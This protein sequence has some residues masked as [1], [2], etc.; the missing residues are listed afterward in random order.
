M[1]GNKQTE[2]NEEDIAKTNQIFNIAERPVM[3]FISKFLDEPLNV[4][5]NDNL[6]TYTQNLT[7]LPIKEY[8]EGVCVKFILKPIMSDS[9]NDDKN[10]SNNIINE[11]IKLEKVKEGIGY[12]WYC[13]KEVFKSL[14][15][16]SMINKAPM[17]NITIE[18]NENTWEFYPKYSHEITQKKNYYENILGELMHY[19]KNI[20]KFP[21][22]LLTD[23]NEEYI[24]TINELSIINTEIDSMP[25]LIADEKKINESYRKNFVLGIFAEECLESDLPKVK[26]ISTKN[27]NE[28]NINENVK[29]NI[30][31]EL[32]ELFT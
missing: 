24:K 20:N 7:L 25:T 2:K 28:N 14:V 17:E 32:T 21:E 4:I 10:L 8:K 22:A 27:I 5:F 30:E 26:D 3:E 13:I 31:N 19:K 12:M 15:L 16:S 9:L 18:L 29:Y 1:S 23:I 6:P 11:I